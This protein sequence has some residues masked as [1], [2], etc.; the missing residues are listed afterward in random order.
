MERN[1]YIN[2]RIRFNSTATDSDRR[3]HSA[4]TQRWDLGSSVGWLPVPTVPNFQTIQKDQDQLGYY[5]W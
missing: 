2:N 1:C 3:R 4:L 5:I